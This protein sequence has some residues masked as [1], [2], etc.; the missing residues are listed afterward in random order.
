MARR[1]VRIE[2]PAATSSDVH[3]GT[4][5]T[6]AGADVGRITSA[7]PPLDGAGIVALGY[8]RR[9]VADESRDVQA[10]GAPAVTGRITG[11]AG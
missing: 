2:F 10:V 6:A 5:L 7:A 3:A 1:L 9:E 11:L 8:V 4:T